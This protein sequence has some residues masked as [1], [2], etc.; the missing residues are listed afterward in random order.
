MKFFLGV[1]D[2][3]K[4]PSVTYGASSAQGTPFGCPRGEPNLSH[5]RCQL[6]T[7]HALRVP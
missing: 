1:K 6:S 4:H 7:R 3:R 2:L 5:L